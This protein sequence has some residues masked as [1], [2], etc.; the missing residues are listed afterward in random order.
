MGDKLIYYHKHLKSIDSTNRYMR[1]EADAL[2]LQAG[3]AT[4]IVVT[5][6]S[7][8]A[9]RG[10]RENIWHSAPNCNLLMSILVKPKS[11]NVK[12]QFY[13]SQ[14]V[15]LAVKRALTEFGI[16]TKLKWPNDIYVGNRKLCGILVELDCLGQNIGQAII[17]IGLNVN[18]TKFQKMDKTPVSMRMISK[19][20][21]SLDKV[22]CSL[23]S[24]FSEYYAMLSVA[25]YKAISNEYLDSLSG[26]GSVMTY[27][28]KS[29]CFQATIKNVAASG[30]IVLQ[31]IDGQES[32][33]AFKEVEMIL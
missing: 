19:Q 17:G 12:E 5:T 21:F 25:R 29:G 24:S 9:G 27:R 28:D 26:Y 3:D 32:I 33:Y 8:T 18:Q 16:E 15:A 20:D 6:D 14:A 11:L 10:Q 13:L 1:D 2:W 7:Q 30:H 4:A 23:L 31:R 22:R